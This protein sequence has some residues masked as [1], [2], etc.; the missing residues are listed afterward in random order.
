VADPE[1]QPLYPKLYPARIIMTMRDGRILKAMVRTPKGD[2]EWTLTRDELLE[3]FRTLA[4]RVYAN[5]QV[6][7]I[8]SVVTSLEELERVPDLLALLAR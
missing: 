7:E 6:E 1:L 3:R 2:P 5:D 8:I 4:G